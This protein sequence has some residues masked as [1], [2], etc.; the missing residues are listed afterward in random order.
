MER[1][2]QNKA[3]VLALVVV[4]LWSTMSSAFKITLRYIEFD[5]LLFWSSLVGIV[6]LFLI[7]RC[8]KNPLNF[9]TLK[10]KDIFSSMLMG[11]FN[12]FLYYLVLFKAYE[13]L[14]AQIAGT[15]NYTWP[16][17]LVI[18]SSIFL[19]QKISTLSYVAILISFFGIIIISTNGTFTGFGNSNIFGIILAIGSSIL[20]ASY[21]IVNLKDKREETGKILLNLIFGFIFI[22][23][24]MLVT[25]KNIT[26][27]T[28]YALIGSIYIGMFEMSI[29]F[30]VWLS[31]LK[32]S[33]NTAKVSNIIFL[34]PFIALMIINFTV[35]ESIKPSTILGLIFIVI[36]I[37]AQKF[38]NKK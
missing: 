27:P 36:G 28:G 33:D 14:D 18:M 23:I 9:S 2:K 35:G 20:W 24:Y 8:I 38:L 25:S 12:P 19:R 26:L 31:A 17:T 16:L 6:V 30:V 37:L 11:L 7:N 32:N 21:W 13:L 4:V 22:T 15:L 3:Y 10:P 1:S 5:L 29:T 34:S